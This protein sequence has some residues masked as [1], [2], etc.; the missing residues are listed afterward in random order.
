MNLQNLRQALT[1]DDVLMVPSYS[2]VLPRDADLRTQLTPAISLNLP[3]VSAA[4]DTVT[5][6]RMAIAMARAGGI[7]VVHKNL[8][9]AVQAAEVAAVK[10]SESR[11]IEAPFTVSPDQSVGVARE[12]MHKHGISGLPVL[13]GERVVGII[14]RRDLRLPGDDGAVKDRMTHEVVTAAISSDLEAWRRL[15]YEHRIEKLPIVNNAGELAGLVTLRDIHNVRD[16]PDAAKD[17]GG[18]LRV[19]AA[20]GVGPKE[21]QRG[22]ALL[23]AGCDVLVI[24]TAHGHSKGVM[25]QVRAVKAAWPDAQVVAGNVATAAAT[26]ALY[27]AGADC[28]KVGIGPGSICTTRVVAGVGVPQFTAINDCSQIAREYDRPIIADGGIK[29]SGDAVKALAGGANVVMLGSLFAGTD[30]APGD[31]ILY[32]GRSYKVYRGMG[33]IGAMKQGSKDR[34]FQENTVDERKLVPEGIEGRVPY[35]GSVTESLYQ[36]AGGV[37]AGMGYAGCKDLPTLHENACFVQITGAGLTESHV[38]DVIITR[39]APNYNR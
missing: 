25:D 36:L 32:Q 28:V 26:K 34:Y 17:S 20:M 35:K 30:Q 2:E 4:M 15:L 22:E 23:R 27:D 7:G 6:A 11:F 29:L 13:D 38:H 5:E 37:R 8:S 16:Y 3:F 18:R 31:V 14:T 33:S 24:D 10:R 9:P 19:A 21:M 12:I 1:F 39:E